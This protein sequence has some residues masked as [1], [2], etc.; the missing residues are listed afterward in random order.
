MNKF[1]KKFF[2]LLIVVQAFC[3]T[4]S[5]TDS[6]ALED[7][8][9][10][11]VNDEVITLKDLQDYIRQTY[12]SLAAEGMPENQLKQVMI[13]LQKDGLNKLIEDKIILSK[14]KEVGLEVRDK[15]VDDRVQE[16]KEKY[17]SEQVFEEALVQNGATLSDL[18]TKVEETLSIKFII[19]HEVKTKIYVNPQ[20]VTDFYKKNLEQFRKKERVNVDSIFI[21]NKG[22][23][24][25]A[26]DKA[27]AA[28]KEINE[29]KDFLEVS[30]RYSDSPSIGVLERGQLMEDV[31]KVIF[32][33]Y[34]G[35]VSDIVETKTGIYIFRLTGK[36]PT[37]VA[38][39]KE[40]KDTIYNVLYKQKFQV[41]YT[42]WLESLKKDAYIEIKQ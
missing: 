12:V 4:I 32:Q 27:E 2:L 13:E 41:E 42:K 40:V 22:S 39:L 29:G 24:I 3:W 34:V 23:R 14:A 36:V 8:I 28:L 25:A 35:E 37:Q 7:A 26:L 20:E 38:E 30:K 5:V 31:E 21:A 17:V 10:A 16:I 33:L 1:K 9:I 18:R 15:L 6:Y 19:D 11:V